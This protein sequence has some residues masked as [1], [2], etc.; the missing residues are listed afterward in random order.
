MKGHDDSGAVSAT[1]IV[2]LMAGATLSLT[3][4]ILTIGSFWQIELVPALSVIGG[5]LAGVAGGSYVAGRAFPT[6]R[7]SYRDGLIDE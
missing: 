6:R 4:L 1:R 5:G 3:T 2:M 7:T